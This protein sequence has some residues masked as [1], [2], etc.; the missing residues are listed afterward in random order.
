MATPAECNPHITIEQWRAL[1]A[2][3]DTGGYAQAAQALHKSQS[4]VTYAV[5][6]LEAL[7][8]VKA[9]EI[10]GR[11]AVL[12][13]TGQLLYRR[14]RTLLEEA[15][16]LERA[17][18][19]LS[20]GWEAEIGLAVDNLFPTRLLFGSLGRF[21]QE[22][23]HTRIEV[24]EAVLN[25]AGEALLQ[26]NAALAIAGYIPEGFLGDVLMPIRMIAVAS[27][28]HPLHR[29]KRV[30]TPRDLRA[31]RHL[32]VRDSSAARSGTALTI[33]AKQRWTVGNVTTSIDAVR[34]GYG[35]AWFPDDKISE[36]LASGALKPLPLREGSI[37]TGSLYL[38]FADRGAAGPG[39][40]RLADIIR[41]TVA[42]EC[43]RMESGAAP[44][45]VQAMPRRVAKSS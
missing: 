15:V 20:A 11:K 41:E 44:A 17:A 22:S 34:R 26:G 31:H 27:P 4:A 8:N 39:T 23:P 29:L 42:S 19:K 2:V 32:V 21:A 5:Q 43:S 10:Q 9:F 7:L 35:F 33:D 16:S 40:L 12:T 37:R 25:G 13:P 3:V 38:V 1:L 36:E 24:I 6:K 30:L 18:R 28:E 45:P 14:A